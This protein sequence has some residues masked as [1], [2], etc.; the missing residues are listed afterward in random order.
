MAERT[1]EGLASPPKDQSSGPDS[2]VLRLG[3]GVSLPTSV[4]RA[5]RIFFGDL[6]PE[7]GRLKKDELVVVVAREELRLSFLN[8]RLFG[9]L[10]CYST[11]VPKRGRGRFDRIRCV[12][13]A[14][15][16]R[17]YSQ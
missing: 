11:L 15:D 14:V 7:R 16:R 6:A 10:V 13:V 1:H 9:L 2:I 17:R 3:P 12:G 5:G 4:L 8:L